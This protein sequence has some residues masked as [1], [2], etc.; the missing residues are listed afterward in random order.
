MGTHNR[1]EEFSKHAE[2]LRVKASELGDVTKDLASD[3]FDYISKNAGEY[4]KQGVDGAR[5][6]EKTIEGKIKDKPL[7]SVL[8]AAG[9]G[10]VLGALWKSRA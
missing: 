2:Q 10:L 8:V 4:Y 1:H 6:M 3:T 9:I 7:Q 5:K